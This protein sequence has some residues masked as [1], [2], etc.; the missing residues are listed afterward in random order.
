M[1]E[2]G[3]RVVLSGVPSE[4]RRRGEI[5]AIVST[6]GELVTVQW[7]ELVDGNHMVVRCD[8]QTVDPSRIP[9]T[10]T[11]HRRGSNYRVSVEVQ[12]IHPPPPRTP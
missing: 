7:G 5:R 10:V 1:A 8:V 4:W 3:C 9:N 11:V 12:C 6:F 2:Y